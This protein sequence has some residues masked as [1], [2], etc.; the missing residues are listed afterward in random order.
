MI[1]RPPRSTQSRS[2]AASDV[3]KRQQDQKVNVV[4]IAKPAATSARTPG[5]IEFLLRSV[6][7]AVAMLLES[8][9]QWRG[10][11]RNV[12]ISDCV[13]HLEDLVNS[14]PARLDLS[15]IRLEA[16]NISNVPGTNLMA[17]FSLR[18]NTNGS[19]RS[20]ATASFLPTTAEIQ[21]DFDKIDLGSL[22]AYLE[23]KVNLYILDSK[24]GLH[25]KV[26][27]TTLPGELPQVTFH[28]DAGLDGFQTVDGDW[29]EDLLKWDSLRFNGIEANLNPQT[30]AIREIVVDNA[31]AR[32]VIETNHTINLLN[33]LRMTN[34]PATNEVKTVAVQDST[35]TNAPL[36]Q[37]S[38]GTIIITNTAVSFTDRSLTPEV[39]LAIQEV[40]GTVAGIS[41]EQMQHAIVDLNAK[42]DGVGPAA[43]TGLINPLNNEATN[44]LKISLK[45]MD[46]T[47]ASSYAAKF[48]GYRIAQ[49]KL[50][51]D[52]S[53][54]LV[55][56]NLKSKNVITLDRFTFGE[57]V[58]SPEATHLPVRLAI[59]ILK[60]R[61]G[62]IVLQVP[63]EAR[64]NGSSSHSDVYK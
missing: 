14:R 48:A 43:I 54:D 41:T 50:N 5:G 8:T 38:V 10:T 45:D 52:L 42:V 2:S 56:K 6:T 21:M 22:D 31:Y 20:F 36:P 33:A 44:S 35:A 60:D 34:A 13:L 37:I 27:L 12:D 47:P 18:W 30:V 4:E 24:I 62:I 11:V 46:L 19:I 3:Y 64:K 61:N 53:Y 26:N 51:L 16:K 49:G 28:G 15:D 39:N 29:A 55:G 58:D 17:K 40:N 57:K 25:G 32:L 59:A 23:P 1:R 63:M 7:N 9:N